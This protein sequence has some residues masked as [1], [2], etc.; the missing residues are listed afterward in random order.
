M[1]K[2]QS[3]LHSLVRAVR[4]S[5]SHYQILGSNMSLSSPIYAGVEV[6]GLSLLIVF[7]GG[8]CSVWRVVE[9]VVVST[10]TNDEDLKIAVNIIATGY[11]E[12]NDSIV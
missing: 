12:D 7:A 11:D 1:R 3:Q 9:V 10:Q 4:L 5:L 2:I 6:G 8:I